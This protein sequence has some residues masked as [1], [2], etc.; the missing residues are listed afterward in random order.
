MQQ[1]IEDQSIT[2]HWSIRY[3]HQGLIYLCMHVCVW[4][5]KTRMYCWVKHTCF[6]WTNY[7]YDPSWPAC[8]SNR[9]RMGSLYHQEWVLVW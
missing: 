6:R 3:H 7:L 4:L 1:D 5:E 2:C 9:A 8:T